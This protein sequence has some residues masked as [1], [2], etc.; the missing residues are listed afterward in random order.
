MKTILATILL[1]VAV[2]A[3]AYIPVKQVDMIKVTTD[4]Q[5]SFEAREDHYK[6]ALTGCTNAELDALEQPVTVHT[7][8][9]SIRDGTTIVFKG[10]DGH[11][12]VCDVE[13]ISK[14]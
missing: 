13:T 7:Q 11:R 3:M 9:R 2:P 8:S 1:L 6:A 12:V 5:A 14:L 4:H 10:A